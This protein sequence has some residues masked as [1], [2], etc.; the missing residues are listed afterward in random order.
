MKDKKSY[1]FD[2]NE[3]SSLSL[4]QFIENVSVTSPGL[5]LSI[6]GSITHDG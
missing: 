4:T 1:L 6:P 5:E 3:P 2:E